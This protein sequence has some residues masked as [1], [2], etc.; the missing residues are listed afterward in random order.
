[1][2]TEQQEQKISPVQRAILVTKLS[3]HNLQTQAYIRLLTRDGDVTKQQ[4]EELMTV[5]LKTIELIW[6]METTTQNTD[7]TEAERGGLSS[8]NAPRVTPGSE[9][10]PDEFWNQHD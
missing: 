4:I 10:D 5:P 2:P 8:A 3:E 9:Q 6:N 7:L 1:M